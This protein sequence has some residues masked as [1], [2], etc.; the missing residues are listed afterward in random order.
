MKPGCRLQ[1][2]G[3]NS[4]QG[5]ASL[6]WLF[7]GSMCAALALLLTSLS[8]PTAVGAQEPQQPQSSTSST[9]S[10]ESAQAEKPTAGKREKE[11]EADPNE[12]FRHSSSVKAVA[13]LTGLSVDAAYWLCV[14]LNFLVIFAVLWFLLRKLVPAI[15][16]NRA[17][18]VQRRLEEARKA[19]E[20]ARRRLS[21]VEARLSRLD[22]E[23]AQMQRE[24]EASARTEEEHTMK[25]AEDERR[26][27]VESAEQEI[28]SA[29]AAA[30]RELKAYT[31]E[32]AVSL[33]EKKIQIAQKTDEQL[34]RGFASRLGKDGN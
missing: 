8:F 6:R 29:A 16:R 21:E 31:A 22:S 11:A 14:V 33:A 19:S 17:E 12:V 15:F 18:S 30:R 13:K 27:I 3:N 9:V 1:R 26:R 5:Q 24:A 23:I 7:F 25:A 4:I 20:D 34:V 28:T 32:L 2:T 10:S